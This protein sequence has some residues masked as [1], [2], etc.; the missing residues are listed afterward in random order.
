MF[1][2]FFCVW[3]VLIF[4]F[5]GQ[6]GGCDHFCAHGASRHDKEDR[7]GAHEI[8]T[9]VCWP[10]KGVNKTIIGLIGLLKRDLRSNLSSH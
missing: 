7:L 8:L 5:L 9:G 4:V 2:V 10:F 3:F 6:E 1:V